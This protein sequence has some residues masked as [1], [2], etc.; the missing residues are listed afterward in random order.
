VAGPQP[1]RARAHR[2]GPELG[3]AIVVSIRTGRPRN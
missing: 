1:M 3:G 2:R